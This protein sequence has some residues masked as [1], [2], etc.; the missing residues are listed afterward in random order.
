MCETEYGQNLIDMKHYIHELHRGIFGTK[1]RFNL[2]T[3]KNTRDIP[4][5][6]KLYP[7]LNKLK[8]SNNNYNNNQ[9]KNTFISGIKN[10]NGLEDII[11]EDYDTFEAI[12]RELDENE[13]IDKETILNQNIT[14]SDSEIEQ[15]LTDID[16]VEN[17]TC[18]WLRSVIKQ[19]E[20]YDTFFED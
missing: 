10:D 4:Q 15:Y 16:T 8:N 20:I 19:T 1:V 2:Y 3:K 11:L 9:N 6:L 12:I 14:L 17:I 5:K 7:L 13:Q 18:N